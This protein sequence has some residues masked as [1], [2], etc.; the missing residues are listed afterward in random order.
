MTTKCAKCG[1][2]LAIGDFAYK[3]EIC[4]ECFKGMVRDI[5]VRDAQTREDEELLEHMLSCMAEF[6]FGRA[7]W[8][9]KCK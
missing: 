5:S 2:K 3:Q 7:R 6:Y 9:E 1:W 4:W 8:K